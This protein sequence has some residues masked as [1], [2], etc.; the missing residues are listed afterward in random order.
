MIEFYCQHCF[1]VVSTADET[2]GKKGRC[3]HCREIMQIPMASQMKQAKTPTPGASS[4]ATRPANVQRPATSPQRKSD[5]DL[6]RTL[7][8]K[9]S[10]W[11]QQARSHRGTTD[12][13][14]DAMSAAQR[15][16]TPQR[17]AAQ[18]ALRG[19]AIGLM[20]L[21]GLALLGV[22]VF[23]L[24][25]GFVQ[26]M[27]TGLNISGREVTFQIVPTLL[28]MGLLSFVQCIVFVG[29]AEMW[30]VGKYGVC[31]TAAMIAILPCGLPSILSTPLGVWAL[32]VLM[33]A[34]VRRA[35]R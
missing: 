21:S 23:F 22:I 15:K 9:P 18:A 28:V 30:K 29:A 32:V 3:P 11:G 31:V 20:I 24:L 2:A 5:D 19:P 7:D 1:E 12:P 35:F 25:W 10:H 13:R 27:T 4:S 33:R 17:L 26:S 14:L 34:D 8:D 16:E 6:F